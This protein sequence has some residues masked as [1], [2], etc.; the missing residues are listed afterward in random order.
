MQQTA[1]FVFELIRVQN[2]YENLYN[3]Q[4]KKDISRILHRLMSFYISLIK[5]MTPKVCISVLLSDSLPAV[6]K[7]LVHSGFYF[8]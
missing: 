2:S 8:C 3:E 7:H 5:C 1:R 4:L 6:V